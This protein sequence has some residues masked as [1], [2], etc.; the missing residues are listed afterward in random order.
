MLSGSSAP[1]SV[2][3]IR[4]VDCSDPPSDTP[5]TTWLP[6]GEVA[7]QSSAAWVPAVANLSGSIS[8]LSLPSIPSRTKSR[9]RLAP[10]G[11]TSEKIFVPPV[12]TLITM[13][14]SPVFFAIAAASSSRPGII[15]STFA[16]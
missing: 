4:A 15:A 16:V 3:T 7:H 9:D 8:V 1:V 11:R 6:S 5:N 10:A 13:T 12:C 14:T 2:T